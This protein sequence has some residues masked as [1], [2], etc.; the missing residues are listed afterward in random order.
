MLRFMAL[1]PSRENSRGDTRPRELQGEGQDQILRMEGVA[2]L[3]RGGTTSNGL[4]KPLG[5]TAG[6]AID[7]SPATAAGPNESPEIFNV[8][9]T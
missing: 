7:G 4:G 6:G 1:L 2:G 5:A 9:G 3:L 8:A